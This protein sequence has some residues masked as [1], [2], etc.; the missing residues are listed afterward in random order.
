MENVVKDNTDSTLDGVAPL[1]DESETAAVDS[2]VK[3]LQ[4]PAPAAV[5]PETVAIPAPATVA[6]PAKVVVK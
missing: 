3:E 5:V 2:V 1:E 4:Q 6:E